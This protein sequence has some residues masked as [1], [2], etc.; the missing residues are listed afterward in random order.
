MLDYHALRAVSAVIQCGS[1]ERA[2]ALLH[3]TPSAVSQ[4]VKTLE[5]RLGTV[6]VVRGAP[7][8]ATE[9]G[10]WLCRHMEQ[11]GLLEQALHERLPGLGAVEQ[12]GQPVTVSV[13]TNADSLG[14]W[15]VEAAAQFSRTGP[16]L[17]NIAVDDEGHTAGWLE[18]GRVSAAVTSDSRPV[19]GCRRIALGRMRYHA[20]ASPDFME[21]HFSGGVTPEALRRAPG[22]TFNQKDRMQSEWV[23][24]V[25][26]KEILF[27]THWLPSTH[28]FLMACRAGLG[29]CLNPAL[30]V[31]DLL[32]TGELVELCPARTLDVCLYW[33]INR[34][35][36]PLLAPLT[37]CIREAAARHLIPYGES[38]TD[39]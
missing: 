29:W 2:A 23:R 39:S 11:V 25:F 26:G 28:G 24:S 34:L 15:F 18:R 16:F 10:E 4:R 31:E 1:F 37:A 6:L 21:R 36:E 33:Q 30:L 9:T 32:K 22:L 20:T 14:T 35:A 38:R 8:R 12:P 17:L 5:E 7:C 19:S 13:A 3:V 27:P